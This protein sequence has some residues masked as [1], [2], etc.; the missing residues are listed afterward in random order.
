[1]RELLKRLEEANIE[2]DRKARKVALDFYNSLR[3]YLEKH[4]DQLV[5]LKDGSFRVYPVDFWRNPKAPYISVLLTP[6]SKGQ[7]GGMGKVGNLDVMVLNVLKGPGDLSYVST[8]LDK[9]TVVHEMIHFLDPG[10]GK[11]RGPDP[12]NANDY[13]NNPSEWNA[14]WQEG[15]ERVEAI[16]S[17]IRR[18]GEHNSGA[19]RRGIVNTF[20][21]GSFKNF[22]SSL[23]SFWDKEFLGH[24]NQKTKKKFDKRLYQLFTEL[25]KEGLW[26]K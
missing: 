5:K 26:S 8:R 21:D 25:K 9:N 22:P 10:S 24:M 19:A 7:R 16:I 14:F 12:T 23:D 13:Y 17:G 20:G 11:G 3:E 15:A 6:E 18:I 4:P 2:R 1:M